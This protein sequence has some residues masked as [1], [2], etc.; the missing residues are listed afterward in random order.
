MLLTTESWLVIFTRKV[1][2]S[3]SLLT[4]L[5][6]L[7]YLIWN[8]KTELS[9]FY[10]SISIFIQVCLYKHKN[11]YDFGNIVMISERH[12]HIVKQYTIFPQKHTILVSSNITNRRSKG[13]IVHIISKGRVFLNFYAIGF[14][15]QIMGGNT[16][17]KSAWI[18]SHAKLF[19]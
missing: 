10:T 12:P 6:H 4:F 18:H 13:N 9:I 14:S 5:L 3:C 8:I 16:T 19:I 15:G 1:V 17:F 11:A 7:Y 2:Y